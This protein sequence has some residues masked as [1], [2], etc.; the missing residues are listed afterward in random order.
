MHILSMDAHSHWETRSTLYLH[1]ERH[2]FLFN[3]LNLAMLGDVTVNNQDRSLLIQVCTADVSLLL[4][5]SKGLHQVLLSPDISSG[6]IP[7]SLW[8][9]YQTLGFKT[10]I[11]QKTF[12]VY[13]TRSNAKNVK[14]AFLQWAVKLERVILTQASKPFSLQ[15]IHITEHSNEGPKDN[16]FKNQNRKMTENWKRNDQGKKTKALQITIVSTCFFLNLANWLLC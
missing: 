12:K 2:K 7:V 10:T 9:D 16:S 4:S 1:G 5:C 13:L 15:C 14:L 6:W 11:F 3:V 8:K